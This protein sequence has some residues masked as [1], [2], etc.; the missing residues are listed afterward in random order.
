ML[1]S[2]AGFKG[3]GQTDAYGHGTSLAEHTIVASTS[4]PVQLGCDALQQTY[5]NR[6]YELDHSLNAGV[7]DLLALSKSKAHAYSLGLSRIKMLVD[8][9]A[10]GYDV[11]YFDLHHVFFRNPLTHLYAHTTAP[12]VVSGT[13]A[14]G[15]RPLAVGAGA[16]LPADH[17]RLDLVFIRS[18]PSSF[19][20]LY[21]WLYLSTHTQHDVGDRPLDHYTFRSAMQE[22]V[23]SL[24]QSTLSVQ[25]LDPH[26]FPSNCAT[27]CG[28]KN[29]SPVP[30]S[31]GHSPA[32]PTQGASG[33]AAAEGPVGGGRGGGG[34]G[35]CPPEVVS[36]WVGYALACSGSS[37]ALAADMA[38]YSEM[39]EAASGS[40]AGG[41]RAL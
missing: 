19:R 20:C 15:C 27:K 1:A 33:A 18:Q 39:W 30:E 25:Y 41:V 11:L 4:L 23:A 21:N 10:L 37:T 35:S 36:Q 12:V 9:V 38:R 31:T 40:T 24:G 34:V 32:A 29:Q 17:H 28:C 22:C 16:R 3:G 5:H 13:P 7:E 8:L 2:L 6:C 14:S 26:A